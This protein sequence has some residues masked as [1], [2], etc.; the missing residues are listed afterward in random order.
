MHTYIHGSLTLVLPNPDYGDKH[1]LDTNTIVRRSRGG[2]ILSLHPGTW[3]QPEIYRYKY[4]GLRLATVQDL[5]AFVKDS[6]A[7]EVTLN[8]VTGVIVTDLVEIVVE[9]DDCAYST[10]LDFQV[11]P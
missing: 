4:S 10:S 8:G 5:I 1:Q 2:D 3:P 9:R 6:Q 11:T 7:D